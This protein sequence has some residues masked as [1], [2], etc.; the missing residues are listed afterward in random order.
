MSRVRAPQTGPERH[1]R[2]PASH[3]RQLDGVRVPGS[4]QRLDLVLVGPS[5]VHIV[6]D[7][8]AQGRGSASVP[9][10]RTGPEDAAARATVAGAAVA[11]LLPERYR[12]AVL[13]EVRLH[14]TA[15]VGMLVGTALVASPDVLARTW[16][17]RRRV[18][19]TSEVAVV[20]R[21]LDE[22]LEIVE[23]APAP[24]SWWTRRWTRWVAGAAALAG[25]GAAAATLYRQ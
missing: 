6:L 2:L 5:G 15:D 12:Q 25:A 9:S 11:G 14:G 3:W 16:R 24:A 7:E 8:P 18:L 10:V 23:D 20:S 22:R 4:D 1:E 17:E 21:L 13:P 19:S